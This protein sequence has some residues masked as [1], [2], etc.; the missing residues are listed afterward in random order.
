MESEHDPPISYWQL[1]RKQELVAMVLWNE[2]SLTRVAYIFKPLIGIASKV[3]PP[4][5]LPFSCCT[6]TSVSGPSSLEECFCGGPAVTLEPNW[7]LRMHPSAAT[8]VLLLADG[9]IRTP[10]L[11]RGQGSPGGCSTCRARG[12]LCCDGWQIRQYSPAACMNSDRSPQLLSWSLPPK[13]KRCWW[14]YKVF[15]FS[16]GHCSNCWLTASYKGLKTSNSI[17]TAQNSFT[18]MYRNMFSSC[19]GRVDGFCWAEDEL[20]E[21]QSNNPI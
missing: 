20:W 17:W 18:G 5:A 2:E 6:A 12:R 9:R 1:R 13:W 16:Y 11:A 7:G 4:T 21:S 10:Q 15:Y 3:A 8:A 14:K 19:M